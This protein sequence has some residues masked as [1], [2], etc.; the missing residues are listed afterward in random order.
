MIIHTEEEQPVRGRRGAGLRARARLEQM[1][2]VFGGAPPASDL[3]ERA[4]DCSHHMAEKSVSSDL[5]RQQAVGI[6]PPGLTDGPHRPSSGV[7]SHTLKRREIVGT[8][9]HGRGS[10][11]GR[12][13][14]RL[15]KMP[16][17]GAVE[18]V[19]NRRM[20]NSILIGLRR[21]A[22]T[23]VEITVDV[24][25][26]QHPDIGRQVGVERAP[27]RG[28]VVREA[29]GNA[30]DLAERVDTSVGSTRAVHGHVS[31]FELRE[32]VLER[33]L[34]GIAVGLPLPSDEAGSVVRE[35]ELE[36]AI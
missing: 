24:A 28:H 18:G 35:R 17:V 20:A 26:R 29:D 3:D 22:E 30:G 5:I 12:H 10:C 4:N 6:T 32:G 7:A 11:H 36:D 9:E 13:I 34:H 33:T 21:R 25:D 8:H 23:S 31:T 2:H 19:R 16:H 27:Q 1:R 14:E 15:G